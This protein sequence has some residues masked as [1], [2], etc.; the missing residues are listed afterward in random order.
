MSAVHD[1][2]QEVFFRDRGGI[3][4]FDCVI[5][6]MPQAGCLHCGEC[7]LRTA[8]EDIEDPEYTVPPEDHAHIAVLFRVHVQDVA[9]VIQPLSAEREDLISPP[10]RCPIDVSL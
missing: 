4:F 3:F 6:V 2:L 7:R 9:V 5:P 1:E 8:H 10:E